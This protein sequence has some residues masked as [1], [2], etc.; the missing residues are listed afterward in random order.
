MDDR[1]E[2]IEKKLDHLSEAV[3]SLAR[4]EERMITLFNR[5]DRYELAQDKIDEKL[6]SVEKTSVSRGAIFRVVDKATWIIVGI[7]V[8]LIIEIFA[9]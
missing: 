2:R 8:A 9:R 5:M 3:V 1:L 6:A 4:M 7:T